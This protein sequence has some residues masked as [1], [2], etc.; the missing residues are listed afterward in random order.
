MGVI[1]NLH[2]NLQ[3][4]VGESIRLLTLEEP[5]ALFSALIFQNAVK[6]SLHSFGVT[7]ALRIMTHHLLF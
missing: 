4:L 2:L 7:N 1:C 3:N 5:W 6:I